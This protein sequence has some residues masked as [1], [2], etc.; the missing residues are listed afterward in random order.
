MS[1]APLAG[2]FEPTV[3]SRELLD[4]S[5]AQLQTLAAFLG[6][7]LGDGHSGGASAAEALACKEILRS[8]AALLARVQAAR[9]AGSQHCVFSAA[10]ATQ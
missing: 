9:H 8:L 1:V 2:V 7:Q 5:V 3:T 6:E 10:T 4:T